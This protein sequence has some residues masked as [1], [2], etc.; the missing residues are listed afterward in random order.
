MNEIKIKNKILIIDDSEDILFLIEN[1]LSL[2][3]FMAIPV[4]NAVKALEIF[5]KTIDAV[6]LDLMMPEMDGID[7][8]KE[9]R[10]RKEYD[11][12]PIIVLTAKNNSDE[13]IAKIYEL[14]ANDYIRKP[15]LKEE[16][17]SKIKVN[18]RLKVLTERLMR[19]NRKLRKKN[20]EI[21]KALRREE[22]LNK[23]I[24]E[25]TMEIK[26]AKEQIEELNKI[27]K[28]ASTHDELTT[29]YNRA[30]IF[31]FLENDI[32]RIKRIKTHISL[33]MF[34]ID[35]FK[36][37][38]D[39]YGHTVGDEIL[40]SLSLL[41]KNH[42]REIDLMGRYGGE[43]FLIILPDTNLQEAA[44]MA[45]RILNLVRCYEFQ[46][47][48]GPINLTISIGI[49]EYK[50]G[51]TIDQFIER[52]DQKLYEAKNSGRNCIKY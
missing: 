29:L 51:E 9:I 4:N 13:E 24:L 49:A 45:E 36:N 6:I 7:F 18:V 32:N 8:L 52:V 23:K 48:K 17:V 5:D 14:G 22:L 11:Y 43:E 26:A 37:I 40:R 50:E 27:L 39:T 33:L 19:L 41:I 2:E 21:K 30:A 31:D 3:S 47:S 16:F 20:R 28:Y 46:T 42:I 10:K 1:I 12:I 15:F 25:R 38:N 44:I 35:F 34:D